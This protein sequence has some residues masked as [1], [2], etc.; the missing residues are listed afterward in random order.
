MKLDTIDI[1]ILNELQN[2]SSHSNLE[3]AKRVH[4]SPSPCLMRVKA[5]KDKGVI[6]NYVALADP[7][8]LGLGLNVFISISLKEQSKEALAEFEKRISEHDEV[9]ECY[10]MTGDSDY[11]I[12]VA[13]ADMDALEKFILEQLT[14]IAGIEKIRSSF[15]LKQVRYKTALPL[16]K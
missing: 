7:K 14:P 13:V 10:L 16:P 11:L 8:V 2:D 5:L 9:M 3:L 1:R 6:R 12:R 4:L 15:A